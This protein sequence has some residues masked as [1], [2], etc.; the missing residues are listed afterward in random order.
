MKRG[1]I[2]IL[3]L[4]I[5]LFGIHSQIVTFKAAFSKLDTTRISTKIL[6]DLVIPKDSFAE[7]TGLNNTAFANPTDW[8]NLY[9]WLQFAHIKVCNMPTLQTITDNITAYSDLNKI[10]I[11]IIN[12]KYNA[13]KQNAFD[14]NLLDY[15]DDYF[16]DGGNQSESPYTEGRCFMASAL[17][18][19][20]QSLSHTFILDEDFFFT[21][22]GEPIQYFSIDFDDGSGNVTLYPN[23]EYNVA[24]SSYGEKTIRVEAHSN[25]GVYSC[26]TTLDVES[27]PPSHIPP[28]SATLNVSATYQGQ[29]FSGKYRIWYGCNN[30]DQLKKPLIF[31]EG[32]DPLNTNKIDGNLYDIANQNGLVEQL[33]NRGYDVIILDFANGGAKIQANAMVLRALINTIN[34]QKTTSNELV[35]VGASMGGLVARYALAYMEHINE[36][37]KTRLYVSFDSPHQGAYY[38]LPAQHLFD[39]FNKTENGGMV[40]FI[41]WVSGV[42]LEDKVTYMDCDAAKQMVVYHH[43]ATVVNNYKA[44]PH[45]LRTDFI[46]DL[47]SLTTTG[48]PEHCRKIAVAEGSGNGTIQDGHNVVE[49]PYVDVNT[50]TDSYK[51]ILKM[52][53]VPDG[54]AKWIFKMDIRLRFLSVFTL[55]LD[56]ALENI[57]I[58]VDNTK[59]YDSAPGGYYPIMHDLLDGLRKGLGLGLTNYPGTECFIPTM[60]ALD[61]RSSQSLTYNI[62]DNITNH[63]NAAE[64]TNHNVT[65]FDAIYVEGANHIHIKNGVTN[66]VTTEMVDWLIGQIDPDNLYLQNTVYSSKPVQYEAKESIFAGSNVTGGTQGD[67]VIKD[68]SNI[69]LAAGESIVLGPGFSVEAGS[70]F[71]AYIKDFYC[72]QPN[73]M[74]MVSPSWQNNDAVTNRNA[75]NELQVDPPSFDTKILKTNEIRIS[76]NPSLGEFEISN[77]GTSLQDARILI[78]D[79]MGN[80]ICND[81]TFTGE[82]K[83]ISLNKQPAGIYLLKVSDKNGQVIVEKIIKR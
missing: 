67:V 66:G 27:P 52:T 39:Q 18:N 45:Q 41:L 56:P 50:L 53:P 29:S 60:S 83:K 61:I 59:P 70:T 77:N 48:Y 36:D 35:I 32:F 57:N 11:G 3:N 31:V 33:R 9:F 69:T 37:H 1:L 40:K 51:I 71:H 26:K 7:F 82:T 5:V 6:Y 19:K 42:A 28:S 21:E 2:I 78:Y 20:V 68:N 81:Y 16:W 65:P 30:D 14:D 46:S 17:I 38:P 10:P 44:N 12:R 55:S 74:N 54:E 64:I 75:N 76:P 13:I 72:A 24:Y 49:D 4:L 62:R 43:S 34:Q 22:E 63:E 58:A 73:Q 79:L 47:N 15:Y 25:Y 80:T 23:D 8:E